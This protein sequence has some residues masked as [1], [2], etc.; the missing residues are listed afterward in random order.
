MDAQTH[1]AWAVGTRGEP[2]DQR[3]TALVDAFDG[4]QWRRIDVPLP[5]SRT[6]LTQVSAF[7]SQNVWASGVRDD[8]AG[9]LLHFDGRQWSLQ[10]PAMRYDY[11]ITA[12]LASSAQH[13]WSVGGSQ[14]TSEVHVEH[15][16][17]QRWEGLPHP[18]RVGEYADYLAS[19]LAFS[20]RDV[21]VLGAAVAA[22]TSAPLVQH[23]DGRSWQV[24][25]VPP[26]PFPTQ[27]GGLWAARIPGQRAFW[28]L[29]YTVERSA[30]LSQLF[31]ALYQQDLP[32]GG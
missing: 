29:G 24:V 13:A 30:S 17:G 11:L 18:V 4:S 27:H 3:R 26:P 25:A 5:V 9:L 12:V 7:S 19:V 31:L 16:T 1:T 23:W 32:A 21:W 15:W 10:Q 28:A 14:S 2:N 20:E 8:T 6:T 22:H